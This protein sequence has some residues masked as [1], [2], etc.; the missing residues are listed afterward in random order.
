VPHPGAASHNLSGVFF[1]EAYE[2]GDVFDID[3]DFGIIVSNTTGTGTTRP[4][5]TDPTSTATAP[6]SMI[7]WIDEPAPVGRDQSNFDRRARL[8]RERN[9]RDRKTLARRGRGRG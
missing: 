3:D 8:Q 7:V 5:D 1:G 9:A 4:S 2:G 6:R